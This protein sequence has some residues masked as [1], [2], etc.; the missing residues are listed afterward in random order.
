MIL[1]ALTVFVSA[2]LLFLVQP[3][4]AKQILPWF[5]G[6]AAVWTTCLVFF[7]CM[8]LAGYFYADWTTKKLTPK[9]QALLHMALI[10]VAIAMLPIIPDPSWKP[11]GEEAPSLRIL[12]LLG[13]TIGLPY[14]L[15][16]TTSPLIQVW[17][18]KRYPGASPYRLFALSNLA[19]MI[20]LLGYP[21]LFEPWIATQ[22]QAI[23]WSFGFGVF[24]VLIAASAWFGLYGRGGEPENI[25]AV[26]PSPDAAEIINPPARRDKLTWIAL[27]AL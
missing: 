17:F 1:Y 11:T 10:V 26:E 12:L 2:F 23:G 14:F 25:A 21:F 18:S 6:S 13:A 9:R 16:S 8:L 7:Q 3:V 24:A 19:S 22:Q 15:I 4:I 27:S 20:A 5:G